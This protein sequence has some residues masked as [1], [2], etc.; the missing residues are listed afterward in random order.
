MAIAVTAPKHARNK[1]AHAKRDFLTVGRDPD[2]MLQ[3]T[4]K[5]P[6]ATGPY[7]MRH[8]EAALVLISQVG[9][10]TLVSRAQH[11]IP[12]VAFKKVQVDIG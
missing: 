5:V 1:T 12:V 9:P 8:S 3:V 2:V 6:F 4:P 11:V 7:I 10:V